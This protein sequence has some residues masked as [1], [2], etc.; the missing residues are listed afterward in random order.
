[1]VMGAE[2]ETKTPA[3]DCPCDDCGECLFEKD[4]DCRLPVFVAVQAD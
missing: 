1:M 4:D 3:P 2:V